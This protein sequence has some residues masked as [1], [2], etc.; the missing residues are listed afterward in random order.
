[1]VCVQR[2]IDWASETSASLLYNEEISHALQDNNNVTRCDTNSPKGFMDALV[3]VVG[4]NTKDQINTIY[5]IYQSL[6]LLNSKQ[7][8]KANSPQY[9]LILERAEQEYHNLG[10]PHS[11]SRFS[12]TLKTYII[13]LTDLNHNNSYPPLNLWKKDWN[14]VIPSSEE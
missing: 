7:R 13:A 2:I 6:I 5:D 12:S 9:R 1:M 4:F 3:Y 8:S 14:V 10:I 11:T